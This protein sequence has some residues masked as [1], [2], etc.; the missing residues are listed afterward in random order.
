STGPGAPSEKTGC[1]AASKLS[2]QCLHRITIR[3]SKRGVI[4]GVQLDTRNNHG[5]A[6][7]FMKGDDL[8]SRSAI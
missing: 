2:I 4:A 1:V 5:F 7:T 6:V 3:Y 8:A